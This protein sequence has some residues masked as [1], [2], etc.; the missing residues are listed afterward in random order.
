MKTQVE[1]LHEEYH[2]SQLRNYAWEIWLLFPVPSATMDLLELDVAT[3]LPEVKDWYQDETSYLTVV[4][5]K[6]GESTSKKN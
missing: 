2:G 3:Y 1:V 6:G 4:E 5:V